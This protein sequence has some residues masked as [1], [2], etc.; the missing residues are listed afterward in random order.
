MSSAV[1]PSGDR[2]G[3]P[4]VIMEALTHRLPVVSTDVCGIPEVIQNGVTGL[5]VK[6]NDPQSLAYGI[7]KMLEDRE[8]AVDMARKGQELVLREFNQKKNHRKIF[9]LLVN[10]VYGAQN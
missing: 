9:D 5:L 3:L 1:H 8:K 7:R 6:Q 2:D 4:T 10:Q